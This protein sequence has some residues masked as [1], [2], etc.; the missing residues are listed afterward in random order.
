MG[1][2]SG[3]W[4]MREAT[5]Q[6]PS[7][8]EYL[9]TAATEKRSFEVYG[10][11]WNDPECIHTVDEAIEYI[12]SVGFLPLFKNDIFS[13]KKQA[14]LQ[15]SGFHALPIIG[16]MDTTLMLCTRM[17]KRLSGKRKSWIFSWKKSYV[18]SCF[19]LK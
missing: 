12:N 16:V 2:E 6:V 11:D 5:S 9:A 15:R 4:I 8:L 13:V 1:N 17:E 19:L 10:V 7:L 14:L 18:R 3:E